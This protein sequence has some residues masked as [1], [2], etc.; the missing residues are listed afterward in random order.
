DSKASVV[1]SD[2]Y[3]PYGQD[4]GAMG[5]YSSY[6][7][8]DRPW[9]S[10]LGLFFDNQRWHD[11]T[12]GRFISQDPLPGH[13]R[14]PQSLNRY[15]YVVNQP[16]FLTD[17]TGMD[18]HYTDSTGIVG[19]SAGLNEAMGS[20]PQIELDTTDP[21]SLSAQPLTSTEAAGL[22]DTFNVLGIENI[23]SFD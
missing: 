6:K 18:P 21:T 4:N 8:V 3:Q 11:P 9:N 17:P 2:N 10:L 20:L 12:T 15:V 1:F 16:T 23:E 7:Y 19:L 5:G 22:A 14:V 13:A